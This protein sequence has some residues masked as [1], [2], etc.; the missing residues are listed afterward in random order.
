M[1][2]KKGKPSAATQLLSGAAI[3][4]LGGFL[5]KTLGVL[6]VVAA[7]PLWVVGAVL[8]GLAVLLGPMIMKQ[9][10]MSK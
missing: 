2:G 4:A 3:G 5:I 9:L 6:A 8:G 10:G 7:A 1:A